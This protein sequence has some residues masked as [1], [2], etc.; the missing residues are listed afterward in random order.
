MVMVNAVQKLRDERGQMIA[1][2]VIVIP[3]LLLALVIIVNTGMFF[4]EAA[5]FD[6]VSAELARGL[7]NSPTDPAIAAP[8]AL[9][10]M[11]GYS[12]GKKGPY[13]ARVHVESTDEIF[14]QK[15]V[16]NF[17]LDYELFATNILP[18]SVRTISRSKTL[19]IYWSTGL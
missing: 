5:R 4:A 11:L 15:R 18:S 19:V 16:L 8:A 7:V 3:A 14:L 2:L 10:K 13:T 1:E 9:Q 17:T 12:G 6:R